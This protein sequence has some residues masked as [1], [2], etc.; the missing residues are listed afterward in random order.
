MIDD[1][2][3][4]CIMHGCATWL[5]GQDHY[6][7]LAD[8]IREKRGTITGYDCRSLWLQKTKNGGKNDG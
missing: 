5:R 2:T 7:P 8:E 4:W 1:F 3:R 6:C